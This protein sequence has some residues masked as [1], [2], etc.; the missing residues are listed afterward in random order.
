LF[1]GKI[2]HSPVHSTVWK[3][4]DFNLENIQDGRPRFACTTWLQLWKL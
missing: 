3:K 2:L 4:V 1:T